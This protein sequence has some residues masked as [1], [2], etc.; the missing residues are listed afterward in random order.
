MQILVLEWL[1]DN[2]DKPFTPHLA[3]NKISTLFG[4]TFENNVSIPLLKKFIVLN[5]K[6]LDTNILKM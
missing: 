1:K 6:Y 4:K 5:F 3:P 2:F